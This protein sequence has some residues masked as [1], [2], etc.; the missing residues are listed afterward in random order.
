MK[1]IISFFIC[2]FIVSLIFSPVLSSTTWT[3]TAQDFNFNP[4]NLPNVHVSDTIKW[5][6]LGGTHTTTSTTIPAGAL[7]WDSP[8]NN[9]VQTFSYVVAV[10]GSYQYKCTPHF[11]MM[12]GSFT[13]NP[14][15]ITPISG[16]VP[17]SFKLDQNYPNPFNPVTNIKFDIPEQSY[18][19]MTIFNLIGGEV[20]VLVNQQ[21]PAGSYIADWDATNSVSGIYI[22][23][24]E[25]A[26]YSESK[27]MVL[28]K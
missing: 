18:V 10:A 19:K 28:V 14:N 2:S 20:E 6:W 13:A 1:K 17:K 12:I 7:P 16:S 9:T 25:T 26:K 15:G 23:K 21:L 5:Q 22:Y 4:S 24:I 27:K 8:L 11:P 3:V